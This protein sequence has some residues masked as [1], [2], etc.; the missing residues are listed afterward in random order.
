MTTN[1]ETL[2]WYGWMVIVLLLFAQSTWL[3]L[4][5]GKNGHRRWFWG[6]WGLIQVP[7]PLVI[8]VLWSKWMKRGRD[9]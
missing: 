4:D 1:P 8:Y 2:P 6:I 5:A 9:S 3:F 7:T